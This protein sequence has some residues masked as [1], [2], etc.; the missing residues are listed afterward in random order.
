MRK[1][2]VPAA[3]LRCTARTPDPG[4]AITRS[5]SIKSSPLVSTMAPVTA[6]SIVEPEGAVAM[7]SRRDPGP[8]SA[9][10]TTVIGTTARTARLEASKEK[11]QRTGRSFFMEVHYG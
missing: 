2:G 8:L 1:S 6:K 7:A 9:V 3:V 11:E 10:E 5:L 4:P